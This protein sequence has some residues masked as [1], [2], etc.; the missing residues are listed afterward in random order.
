MGFELPDAYGYVLL[1]HGFSWISN[2]YL[3]INVVKARKKYKVEYP[4][5]Y[6]PDGH[7]NASEFNCVQRAHQNTLENWAPVQLAMAF[8]GIMYPKF[9]AACGTIWAVGR[10]IYGYG[11]AS[12][13][14]QGRMVGGRMT[15]NGRNTGKMP[16]R[17]SRHNLTPGRLP[18]HDRSFRR[19]LQDAPEG[20][21]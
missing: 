7:P 10:I 20:L 12:G 11:Y 6:A 5:L 18:A 13:G 21:S 9:A 8:N 4:A 17:S 19:W 3:V 14:P 15:R 1:A 16:K 2:M